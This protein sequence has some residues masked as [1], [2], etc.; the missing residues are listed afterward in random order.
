MVVED[1]AAGAW[2]ARGIANLLVEFIAEGACGLKGLFF[3]A[4]LPIAEQAGK[5]FAIAVA[6]HEPPVGG[7]GIDA[8]DPLVLIVLLRVH[9]DND[10]RMRRIFAGRQPYFEVG[11]VP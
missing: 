11:G 6:A 2:L 9:P 4:V 5:S 7:I 8:G 10:F 1:D 3:G